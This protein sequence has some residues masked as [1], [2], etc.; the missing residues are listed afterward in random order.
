MSCTVYSMLFSCSFLY[1][2][3]LVGRS[4]DLTV[5]QDQ[6]SLQTYCGETCCLPVIEQC[7]ALSSNLTSR[8]STCCTTVSVCGSLQCPSSLL[9]E[10]IYD[11]T[12]KTTGS[13]GETAQL[14]NQCCVYFRKGCCSQ[15]EN[16]FLDLLFKLTIGLGIGLGGLLVIILLLVVC[17]CCCVC[18]D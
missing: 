16:N 4:I 18:C 9:S 13:T 7:C 11:T 10:D 8:L 5:A 17:C 3:V 6:C 2:I 1:F 15:R 12:V 14:R